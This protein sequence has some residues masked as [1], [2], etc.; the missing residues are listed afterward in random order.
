MDTEAPHDP[1]PARLSRRDLLRLSAASLAAMG[2]AGCQPSGEALPYVEMPE[3]TVPGR[4]GHYATAWRLGG[5]AQPVIATTQVGRPTKL[6]GNPDHPACRGASDLFTQAAILGLYD[7]DRSQVL[8]HGAADAS[9]DDLMAEL[10]RRMPD[11]RADGG[12]AVV[13]G[14]VTSPTLA[15]QMAELG[16]RYPRTSWHLCEPLAETQRAAGLKLAFGRRLDQH[17]RLDRATAIVS[18]DEDLLGFGPTQTLHS[19]HWGEGRRAGRAGGRPPVVLVAESVPG[20]LGARADRRLAGPAGR[21]GALLAGLAARL[22][23]GEAPAGLSP[24]EAAFCDAAATLLRQHGATGLVTVGAHLAPEL[25]AVAC[26]LNY[27]LGAAGRTVLYSPPLTVPAPLPETGLAALARSVA[28][29]R[30]EAL[31]VLDA[32]PVYAAP[33]DLDFAALL[34][35]VP[36]TLH[37]GTALDETAHAC[38]WHVPLLHPFE[39]WSDARAVD[40]TLTVIQPLIR[41]I[42]GG[43]SI[44]TLLAALMGRFDAHPRDIVRAAHGDLDDG[45][46]MEVLRRGLVA[47]SAPA[48]VDPGPPAEIRLPPPMPPGAVEAVIRPDP[49]VWDGRLANISWLQEV[50]DPLSKLTWGNAATLSPSLARRVGVAEGEVLAVEAGGRRIEA[51]VVILP[52]QA[53]QTVGLTLG[54][55]RRHAGAVGDDLGYDANRLRTAAEPWVIGGLRLTPT[56]RKV[57]LARLQLTK[58]MEDHNPVRLVQAFGQSAAAEPAS[59]KALWG[60]WPVGRHAWAMSIDLDLCTGCNA[61]VVACQAENNVPVVGRS[62]VARG[63]AMHWVRLDRYYHDD[64]TLFQPVPC[65]HCEEAPCEVGCPV[66]AAVH[67]SEGINQQ[68]YNRCI[69]TRT[70]ES[71]CPYKV[72]RFNFFTYAAVRKPL[73]AQYN[74]EVTVRGRGVMEKCTYCIQRI[75]AARIRAGV[76]NREMRGD[77]VVPACAQAC[78]TRVITFGDLTE[79]EGAVA[80]LR[81]DPRSYALLGQLNTRPHTTYQARIRPPREA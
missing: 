49:R 70:C 58:T 65:Q 64:T 11:W 73:D 61:C 23:Q 14:S 66:Y 19:L 4:P 43:R 38:R 47:N 56:G 32:N 55:G 67:S 50:G 42:T 60:D 51:P 2:L 36:F 8:R 7:P 33:A 16:R 53:P 80:G 68:V 69:G 39:D 6:E 81:R 78:P 12:L 46:W 24:D 13:T 48:P 79:A 31:L 17:Y 28:A 54:Y 44:H 77:E 37:A 18:L 29:G 10:V 75:E 62:E 30:V 1:A 59:H 76:E 20:L 35:K 34:A 9:W 3:G 63:R 74:P 71:F 72:R 52:D 15:A 25:H 5:W 57:E 22:G 40:G 27:A 45:R 41:P 26:R 21:M